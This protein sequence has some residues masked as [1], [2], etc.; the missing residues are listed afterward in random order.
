MQV[1]CESKAR[2]AGLPNFPKSLCCE[3]IEPLFRSVQHFVALVA[4]PLSD[5]EGAR[6]SSF[7]VDCCEVDHLGD[8][9]GDELAEFGKHHRLLI[10]EIT[11]GL[12]SEAIALALGFAIVPG[13]TMNGI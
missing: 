2:G 11:K 12:V 9:I 8:V 5:R 10:G 6:G 3:A 1:T 7:W 13:I 4:L